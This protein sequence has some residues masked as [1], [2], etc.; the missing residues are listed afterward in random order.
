M[1]RPSY[2]ALIEF[3]LAWLGVSSLVSLPLAVCPLL[4]S[5]ESSITELQCG[6]SRQ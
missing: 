5:R 3:C 4:V 6:Q 1:L 2:I